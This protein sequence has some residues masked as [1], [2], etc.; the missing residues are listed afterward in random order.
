MCRGLYPNDAPRAT[1][2]RGQK[3][4]LVCVSSRGDDLRFEG[5]VTNRKG[6]ARRLGSCAFFGVAIFGSSPLE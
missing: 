2:D 5:F 1:Q 4:S 3:E 6:L